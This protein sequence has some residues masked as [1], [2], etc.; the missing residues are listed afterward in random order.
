MARMFRLVRQPLDQRGR[1]VERT[2]RVA[3]RSGERPGV[4]PPDQVTGLARRQ[5]GGGRVHVSC[6]RN[7]SIRQVQHARHSVSCR[8]RLRSPPAA[9]THASHHPCA[10]TCAT[11]RAAFPRMRHWQSAR[12]HGPGG[13]A[14]PHAAGLAD[15][16]DNAGWRGRNMG[17]TRLFR[18]HRT[19][20][21]L[22]A[23]GS[24][25]PHSVPDRMPA[26]QPQLMAAEQP[27]TQQPQLRFPDQ[28]RRLARFGFACSIPRTAS[29]QPVT[30]CC[31]CRSE[32]SSTI[33]TSKPS[34]PS[35]RVMLTSAGTRSSRRP[36]S[37][38][39]AATTGS[40]GIQRGVGNRLQQHEVPAWLQGLRQRRTGRA[41]PSRHASAPAP[42]HDGI[43]RFSKLALRGPRRSSGPPRQT[44][45]A[46]RGR[47]RGQQSGSDSN[48]VTQTPASL[49]MQH[50]GPPLPAPSSSKLVAAD[51]P[52]GSTS[53]NVSASPPGTGSPRPT[54]RPPP[55]SARPARDS[56]RSSSG[57]SCDGGPA[58]AGL[59]TPAARRQ[60]LRCLL[61]SQTIAAYGAA[62]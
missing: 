3:P 33:R 16:Q 12:G 51:R 50:G 32:T 40:L 60:H 54:A 34:L 44:G 29:R 22:R 39:Q 5:H 43:S 18:G 48:P 37:R 61:Q 4:E 41:P 49:A 30:D 10:T 25:A 53:R 11:I 26:H 46:G 28:L 9:S 55:P 7:N 58:I 19:A 2:A 23:T 14:A 36:S 62:S 57:E 17:R 8:M 15:R 56:L 42:V 6:F 13:P 38:C 35:A 45:A 47:W 59:A 31:M 21:H 20:P 1:G 27:D 24:H 52:S